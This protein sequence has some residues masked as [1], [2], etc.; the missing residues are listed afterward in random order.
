MSR[1]SR[2]LAGY[3]RLDGTLRAS[4][5]VF[6]DAGDTEAFVRALRDL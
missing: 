4:A 6:N 3:P 5:H 1:A 2:A